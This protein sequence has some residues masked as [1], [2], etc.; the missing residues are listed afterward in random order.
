MKKEYTYFIRKLYNKKTIKKL[1]DKIKMLGSKNKLTAEKFLFIR[2][3]FMILIFGLSLLCLKNIFY[4]LAIAIIY[5]FSFIYIIDYSINKRSRV[6]ESDALLFFEVLSL[7]LESGKDLVSALEITTSSIDSNLSKEFKQVLYE[8][9]FGKSLTE[10]LVSLKKRLPS[11]NLKN[12][13]VNMI[14]CY[15]TGGN[16]VNGLTE[17]VE[18]IRSIKKMEIKEKINRLPIEISVVSVVFVVPM[19]LLLILGPVLLEY[20]LNI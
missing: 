15:S 5:Y 7:A 2:I 12:V 8:I 13:V 17:Q 1:D 14:N 18:Y 20:F 3:L 10:A 11:D 6:L 4:A 9:K 19:I 16:L